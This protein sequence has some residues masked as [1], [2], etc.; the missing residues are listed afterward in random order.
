VSSADAETDPPEEDV[1]TPVVADGCPDAQAV[2]A[3][4]IQTAAKA[5]PSDFPWGEL[6]PLGLRR[7]RDGS[8]CAVRALVSAKKVTTGSG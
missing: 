1:R 5:T 8:A 4:A 2:R 3:T 6:M 7:R